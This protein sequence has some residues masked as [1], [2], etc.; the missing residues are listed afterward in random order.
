MRKMSKT[1]KRWTKAEGYEKD[2]K[3]YAG[4]TRT[5]CHDVFRRFVKPVRAQAATVAPATPH[6]WQCVASF[7]ATPPQ[8]PAPHCPEISTSHDVIVTQTFRRWTPWSFL[9][10]C[11]G[12]HVAE[13]SESEPSLSWV[14][15]LGSRCGRCNFRQGNWS[16]LSLAIH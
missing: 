3:R 9:L 14:E 11:H 8:Q 15:R 12:S 13:D 4:R 2:R 1:K 10:P 5:V 6:N 7:G 16:Q